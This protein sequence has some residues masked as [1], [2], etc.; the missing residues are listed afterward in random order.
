MIFPYSS[1]CS[2]AGRVISRLLRKYIPAYG[3]SSIT[4]I[5]HSSQWKYEG[6][7]RTISTPSIPWRAI[8]ATQWTI[9]G[10]QGHRASTGMFCGANMGIL[11][12]AKVT[13][14]D[15][16]PKLFIFPFF[17]LVSRPFTLANI[18]SHQLKMVPQKQSTAMR[19]W[20]P[21]ATCNIALPHSLVIVNAITFSSGRMI[22]FISIHLSLGFAL[23]LQ[24]SCRRLAT[25]WP[26]GLV[27]NKES[28][29]PLLDK[30]VKK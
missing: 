10:S 19:I 25:V 20:E 17:S 27:P 8:N 1:H 9:L 23:S 2:P 18:A 7:N 26:P 6:G 4:E 12:R 30:P 22:V 24:N 3:K 15:P 21:V 28:C 16:Y 29:S 13:T 11:S 5:W 14:M